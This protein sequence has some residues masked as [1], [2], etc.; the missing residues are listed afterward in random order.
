MLVRVLVWIALKRALNG[1]LG[2][3]LLFLNGNKDDFFGRNAALSGLV[4]PSLDRFLRRF[5]LEPVNR[6]FK[7]AGMS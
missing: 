1:L 7:H 4:L 2:G 6:G 5:C 3:R